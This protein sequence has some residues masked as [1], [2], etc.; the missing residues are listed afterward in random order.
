MP[1]LKIPPGHIQYA[2]EHSPTDKK[3]I[4]KHIG[5]SIDGWISGKEKPTMRQ[6]EKFSEKTLMPFGYFLLEEMPKPD[7]DIP[8]FYR[9]GK[10]TK[11]KASRVLLNKF[12]E[13]NNRHEFLQHHGLYN[14][15]ELISKRFPKHRKHDK[16]SASMRKMLRMDE[17]DGK[18]YGDMIQYI[19]RQAEKN[20]IFISTSTRLCKKNT[21]FL[22]DP[23]EFSG[24]V[25][26]EKF[27]PYILIN[28]ND[29]KALQLYTLAFALAH[30]WL[31]Q[32]ALLDTQKTSLTHPI[33]RACAR[34][35]L[36]F[37]IPD[38]IRGFSGKKFLNNVEQT[39]KAFHVS[40][41]VLLKKALDAGII[42]EKQFTKQYEKHVNEP[43]GSKNRTLIEEE[44]GMKYASLVLS[45]AKSGLILYTEAY[46]LLGDYAAFKKY[47]E[48]ITG[49]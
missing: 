2:L 37:L 26:S 41:I 29:P 15:I 5:K 22:L 32:S 25:I 27:I 17:F 24:F 10:G 49:R 42:T 7:F 39:A 46:R 6:L 18:T 44:Y 9:T 48:K 28:G 20:W 13:I 12:F 16:T 11:Y 47:D 33:E 1:R 35:A 23:K 8:P 31:G 30:V 21:A 14:D 36:D 3:G 19:K 43:P 34:I 4:E 40:V 45:S 38:D